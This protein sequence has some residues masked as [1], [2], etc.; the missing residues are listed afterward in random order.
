MNDVLQKFCKNLVFKVNY[1]RDA[2]KSMP[3]SITILSQK[4]RNCALQWVT[5]VSDIVKKVL[6]SV[7]SI[8]SQNILFNIL[9]KYTIFRS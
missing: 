3:S 2:I 8:F 4:G 7:T 5:S 9:G 6:F 1:G